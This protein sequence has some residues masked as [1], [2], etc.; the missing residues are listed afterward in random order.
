MSDDYCVGCGGDLI[1]SLDDDPNGSPNATCAKC[2]A[3][4]EW[5]FDQYPEAKFSRGGLLLNDPFRSPEDRYDEL[6]DRFLVVTFEQHRRSDPPYECPIC[7]ATITTTNGEQSGHE[8]ACWYPE[9]LCL[10]EK[11]KGPF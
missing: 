9:F 7:G 3:E 1:S 2:R 6:L 11:F 8:Q 5:D 4:E 10:V